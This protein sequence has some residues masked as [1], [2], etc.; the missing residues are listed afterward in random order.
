MTARAA[1][2]AELLGGRRILH[3]DVRSG[4]DLVEAVRDGFPPATVDRLANWMGLSPDDVFRLIVPQR[5]LALRRSRG[6]RLSPKETARVV[7]LAQVYAQAEDTFQNAM[8]ARA[9]LRRPSRALSDQVPLEL[10][11]TE[12]GARLVEDELTRI[13]YSVYA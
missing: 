6:T 13:S 2:I 8:R 4:L 11:D 5:T 1:K 10:L 12:L 7:R 9:W 3:R